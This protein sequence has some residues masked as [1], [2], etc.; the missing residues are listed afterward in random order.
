MEL[1]A[2]F[3]VSRIS[4]FAPLLMSLVSLSVVGAALAL[5]VREQADEGIFARVW[6]LLLVGQLPLVGWF[7]VRWLPLAPRNGLAVLAA[8]AIAGLIALSPVYLL[9]L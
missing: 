6:Q 2:R 3:M 4:G 5:G 1:T 9:H 8:Q 7:V